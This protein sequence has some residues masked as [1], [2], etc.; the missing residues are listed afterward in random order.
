LGALNRRDLTPPTLQSTAP[1]YKFL[2]TRLHATHP[3]SNNNTGCTT[4]SR[5]RVCTQ[6]T[7]ADVTTRY[8]PLAYLRSVVVGGWWW[9]Q[10]NPYKH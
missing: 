5:C 6:C 4:G 7:A 1:Q 9:L 2:D 3:T 10:S 8:R